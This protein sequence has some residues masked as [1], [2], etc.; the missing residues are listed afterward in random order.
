MTTTDPIQYRRGMSY[1]DF[2]AMLEQ[3]RIAESVALV[4]ADTCPHPYERLVTA[5]RGKRVPAGVPA[6][7]I[8]VEYT[9]GDCGTFLGHDRKNF[10]L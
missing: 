7:R 1:R 4:P 2:L 10:R 5:I 6:V 9:C 8:I 3:R